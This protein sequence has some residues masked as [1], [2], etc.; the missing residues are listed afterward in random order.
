MRLL[1]K[2]I[3]T[4]RLSG[5]WI[6]GNPPVMSFHPQFSVNMIFLFKKSLTPSV[7]TESN[8]Q[9]HQS[10]ALEKLYRKSFETFSMWSTVWPKITKFRGRFREG[11]TPADNFRRFAAERV[12]RSFSTQKK[13]CRASNF[14]SDGL[15]FK[16]SKTFIHIQINFFERQIF[17]FKGAP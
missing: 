6:S 12:V 10:V 13:K 7:W 4:S 5:C 8:D 14:L 3:V 16:T 1:L 11:A 15:V 17:A 9:A 2:M